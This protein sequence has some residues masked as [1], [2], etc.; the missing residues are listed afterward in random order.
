MRTP[1]NSASPSPIIARPTCA[2]RHRSAAPTEPERG[3]TGCTPSLSIPASSCATAGDAPEPPAQMP[4]HRTARVA[5]VSST[6]NG[7]PTAVARPRIV[8]SENSA[9]PSATDS[10]TREP[11]PVVTP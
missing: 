3:I 1:E 10:V 11:R 7:S 9:P 2:I 6:L 8:R 5:R 4:L